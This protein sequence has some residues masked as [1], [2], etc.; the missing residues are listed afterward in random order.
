MWTSSQ[1]PHVTISCLLQSMQQVLHTG[2]HA[3]LQEDLLRGSSGISATFGNPCLAASTEFAVGKLE[4]W[5][6]LPT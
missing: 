3:A 5:A 2:T 1:G 6:V 4:V